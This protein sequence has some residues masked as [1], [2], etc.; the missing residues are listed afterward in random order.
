[1]ISIFVCIRRGLII[2]R[3]AIELN[4]VAK[5]AELIDKDIMMYKFYL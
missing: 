3:L 2:I 5:G 4:F 1:M